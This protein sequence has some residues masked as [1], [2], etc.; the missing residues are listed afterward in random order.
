M[1]KRKI[2]VVTT[3]RADYG[4]LKPLLAALSRDRRA[5]VSILCSGTHLSKAFGE[6]FREIQ[7]DGFPIDERIPL[8]LGGDR[9]QDLTRALADAVSGFARAYSRR[10]PDLIVILGDR[11]E[12]LGAAAAALPFGIPIAHLHGGEA[13][14]GALDEQVRHAVTKLS[15]LH[16]P[17]APEYRRRILALGEEP[18]RVFCFGAPGLDGLSKL[19]LLGGAALRRE[20][21]APLDARLGVIAYHPVTLEPAAS[22]AQCRMVLA[23]AAKH[24]DIFWILTLPN[25][26]TGNARIARQL[27]AFARGG[28]GAVFAS[29]GRVRFLSALKEA[30]VLM[31]N[32]SS[33]II[34][35]PSFGLPVVNVGRRQAGRVRAVNVI[36]VER[37]TPAGVVRALGRA[38]SPGFRKTARKARNPYAG[39]DTCQK[40]AA[41]LLGVPLDR[42]LI[43]KKIAL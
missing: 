19:E 26:D 16:F 7:A 21:G 37:P 20:V 33:G 15:H 22:A 14:E 12:I 2:A 34:E 31:G 10:R 17:A 25:S 24:P 38:L 1:K 30:E 43:E 32:S 35:A 23:A 40:I 41:V 3:S 29:L 5:A 11:Y 28:R 27:K 13:T 9:P 4:L 8:Y 39:R 42:A 6:T 18:R 36:D